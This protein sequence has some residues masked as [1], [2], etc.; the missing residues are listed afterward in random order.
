[1][2]NQQPPTPRHY[3]ILTHCNCWK[4]TYLSKIPE[5]AGKNDTCSNIKKKKSYDAV[6]VEIVEG[7]INFLTERMNI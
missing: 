2:G 5:E 7:A 1:M 6:R 4:N 3:F